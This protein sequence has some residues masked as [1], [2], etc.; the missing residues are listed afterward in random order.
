L[1][2]ALA[3]IIIMLWRP[4]GLWPTSE[5]GKSSPRSAAG[6]STGGVA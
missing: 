5:H 3:M 1:L 2:I 6:S 4:R